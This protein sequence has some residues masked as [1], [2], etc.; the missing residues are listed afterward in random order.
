MT[1]DFLKPRYE[2]PA[3]IYLGNMAKG[4]GQPPVDCTAGPSATND[5]SAGGNATNDCTAGTSAVQSCTDGVAAS[6]VTCSG[7]S[8]RV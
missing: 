7:G 3:I 6:V 2:P 8:L 1:E 5:C 4:S